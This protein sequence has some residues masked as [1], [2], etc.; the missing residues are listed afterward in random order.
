MN[1]FDSFLPWTKKRMTEFASG[2]LEL[3][4]SADMSV[5]QDQCI[6][7]TNLMILLYSKLNTATNLTKFKNRQALVNWYQKI[8]VFTFDIDSLTK[9]FQESTGGNE[10]V[11]TDVFGINLVGYARSVTGLGEDIRHLSQL[12]ERMGIPYCILTLGH[13]A[14]DIQN[15]NVVNTSLSPIYSFSLF[16]MNLIEFDK[17]TL[18]YDDFKKVFGFTILQA[19]WE[20]PALPDI[21][22]DSLR[23]VNEFWAISKFVEQAYIQAG[24]K[25][26]QYVPP[27]C[28]DPKFDSAGESNICQPTPFTFLYVF[29]AGSYLSRKNP[30]GVVESFQRAFYQS[31]NVRLV[32]KVSNGARNPEFN[33]FR[34]K[35]ASDYRIQIITEPQTSSKITTLY[36]KM[37]CYVSLHRSEGFG[38]TIAEACLNGKPV[39]AT[40]WSGSCDILPANSELLVEYELRDLRENEYPFGE[41]QHWAEPIISS[42]TEKM[43][44]VFNMSKTQRQE[45]GH[46]N[47]QHV[48]DR[49]SIS[50][51]AARYQALFTEYEKQLTIGAL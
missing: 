28:S 15:V 20:L 23:F 25:N 40:N 27:I 44:M 2:E 18:V 3:L 12:L 17:L 5:V 1:K 42:A 19:P 8:G 45:I 35:C 48:A 30:H 41:N 50:T 4:F 14:D 37:D 6:P 46:K 43:E 7:I 9:F 29:D 34:Q 39:I 11:R 26:V 16:C 38:R 31:Q 24:Y 36:E 49:Y 21:P 33:E 22:R 47:R 32:L 13:P 10:I 51:A